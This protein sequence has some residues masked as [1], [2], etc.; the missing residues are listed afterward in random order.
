MRYFIQFLTATIIFIDQ[1][2]TIIYYA[3]NYDIFADLTI[4][5]ILAGTIFI[6]PLI[7]ISFSLCYLYPNHEESLKKNTS[8]LFSQ[9]KDIWIE[10][11]QFHKDF[12]DLRKKGSRSCI[13]LKIFALCITFIPAMLIYWTLVVIKAAFMLVN[14]LFYMLAEFS[15]LLSYSIYIAFFLWS[16]VMNCLNRLVITECLGNSKYRLLDS[17]TKMRLFCILINGIQAVFQ[18]FPALIAKSVNITKLHDLDC[19][20]ILSIVFD[21]LSLLFQIMDAS[22]YKTNSQINIEETGDNHLDIVSVE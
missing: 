20:S 14:Y 2:F 16:R 15:A 22:L 11:N 18:A 3:H 13:I 19:L 10:L 4:R 8:L 7:N 5:K 9:I 17:H 12:F 21:I 1:I 6:V